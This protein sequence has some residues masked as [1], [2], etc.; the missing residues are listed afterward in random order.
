[1]KILASDQR[2][3]DTI[4]RY[5][6]YIDMPATAEDM[7]YVDVSLRRS[8]ND[9]YTDRKGL[10]EAIEKMSQGEKVVL[11]SFESAQSLYSPKYSNNYT[12]FMKIMAQKDSYFI[13]LPALAE[14][15]KRELSETKHYHQAM[16]LA[17]AAN[18]SSNNAGTLLHSMSSKGEH[19]TAD[20]ARK[21]MGL[22]GSDLEIISKLKDLRQRQGG[23]DYSGTISGLFVDIEDT[24]YKDGKIDMDV[25]DKMIDYSRKGPVTI[26]TGGEVDKISL[27][28]RKLFTDACIERESRLYT[29]TPILSKHT[30]R[31]CNVES[32]IDDLAKEE[33]EREYGIRTVEYRQHVSK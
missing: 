9:R 8:Q 29:R 26:W 15:M 16:D 22:T 12:S 3:H 2:T 11:F 31:G 13:R 19:A 6:Q 5:L 21:E 32:A 20:Q 4:E 18:I 24:L 27:T 14:E 7:T 30:F 17:S 33:F 25:I 1:M 28:V 23:I 10:D